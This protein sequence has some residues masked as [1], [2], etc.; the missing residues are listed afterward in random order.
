MDEAIV[1]LIGLDV[2]WLMGVNVGEGEQMKSF[3]LSL[4]DTS[5]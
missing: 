2:E 3:L 4:V 5:R 1:K